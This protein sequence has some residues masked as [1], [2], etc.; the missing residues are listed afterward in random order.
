M[1]KTLLIPY[2]FNLLNLA[3]VAALYHFLRRTAAGDIWTARAG[4][5]LDMNLDKALSAR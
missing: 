5:S 3:S 4:R 2:A 1:K